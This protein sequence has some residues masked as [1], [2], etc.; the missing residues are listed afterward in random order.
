MRPF[1]MHKDLCDT[2]YVW[3]SYIFF[4]IHNYILNEKFLM[5]QNMKTVVECACCYY[6]EDLSM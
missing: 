3:L 2:C 4:C 1:L 5:F 6:Y